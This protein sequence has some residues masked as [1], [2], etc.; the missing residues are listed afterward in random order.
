DGKEELL[1]RGGADGA[2]TDPVVSL[3][4]AWVFYSHLR[5]LKGTSQHGQPPFGGADIYKIHLKTRQIVRLTRQEYTPNTGAADWADAVRKPQPSRT[6]L[7]SGVLNLG[8]SPLPGGW[9]VFTSNRNAFVPPKHP[10]PCLQLFVMDDDG[11]NVECIGHLNVG[12]ALHPVV[13]KDGRVI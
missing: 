8:A 11:N 9:L 2:V 10:S 13:L 7:N 6:H 4:G 1:V 3:D 5:G 12:M